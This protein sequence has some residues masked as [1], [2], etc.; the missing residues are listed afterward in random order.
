MT[1]QSTPVISG[2]AIQGTAANIK[3]PNAPN[4]TRDGKR[5]ATSTL[6]TARAKVNQ[7]DTGRATI[8]API[9]NAKTTAR[10]GRLTRLPLY[11]D[12]DTETSGTV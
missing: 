6:T 7:A 3:S 12:D 11:V 1:S 4:A 5:V 8:C 10:M 2:K 9:D